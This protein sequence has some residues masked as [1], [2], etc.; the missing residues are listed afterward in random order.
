[1]QLNNLYNFPALQALLSFGSRYEAHYPE[2][3]FKGY[4]VNC[5]AIFSIL[6]AMVKPLLAPATVEKLTIYGSNRE[7]WELAVRE[8][9]YPD[10][11][12]VQFGGVC[13]DRVM[14]I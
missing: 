7:E 5:P 3:F 12:G 8:F 4:Y 11:L 1:M 6:F 13:K 14:D 10:Q 2:I 9:I